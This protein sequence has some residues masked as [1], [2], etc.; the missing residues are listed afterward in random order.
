M[1]VRPVPAHDERPGRR[2]R[3]RSGMRPFL[4]LGCLAAT[5]A[6]S[7]A[8]T[9]ARDLVL[10]HQGTGRAVLRM[11]SDADATTRHLRESLTRHT[12]A[13]LPILAPSDPTDGGKAEIVL[14]TIASRAE[15]RDRLPDRL[16]GVRLE[17]EGF[18]I[19]A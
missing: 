12:G 18:A 9:R 14:C 5:V 19:E 15:V 7:A 6:G 3:R 16:R 4:I 2:H 8:M 11:A 10:V 13:T 1:A 17:P